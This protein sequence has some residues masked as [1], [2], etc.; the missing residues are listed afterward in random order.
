MGVCLVDV[1]GG[2]VMSDMETMRKDAIKLSIVNDR[3]FAAVCANN[4]GLRFAETFVTIRGARG[5]CEDVPYWVIAHDGEIIEQSHTPDPYADYEGGATQYQADVATLTEA[6]L[7][8]GKL[9]DKDFK[10]WEVVGLNGADFT[11]QST[12]D[13]LVLGNAANTARAL[14]RFM[15]W[16]LARL[17][18]DK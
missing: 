17:G 10:R 15:P 12:T 4:G 18:G 8:G 5:Y 3:M 16:A 7:L 9:S 13:I 1:N 14:S 2:G 6:G 11:L